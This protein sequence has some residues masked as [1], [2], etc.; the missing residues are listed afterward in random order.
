MPL[1]RFRLLAVATAI[2]RLP[3]SVSHV[4]RLSWSYVLPQRVAGRVG[5]A[6]WV[7]RSPFILRVTPHPGAVVRARRLV[8]RG[9]WGLPDIGRLFNRNAYGEEV[10]SRSCA[11]FRAWPQTG[12]RSTCCSSAVP[13]MRF[14]PLQHIQD[15]QVHIPRA[16]LARFVPSSGFFTL[17]TVFSL[18]A[19]PAIVSSRKRSWG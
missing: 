19:R 10:R 7:Q 5:I 11:S 15:G 1:Q 9:S 12:D 13:F 6:S 8:T 14:I 3:T 18:P 17:L 2:V 4:D 16:C